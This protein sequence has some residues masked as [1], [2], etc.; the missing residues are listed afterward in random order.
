[1]AEG[2]FDIG[3]NVYHV[4]DNLVY[5][6]EA[7]LLEER[8]PSEKVQRVRRRLGMFGVDTNLVVS[9]ETDEVLHVEGDWKVVVDQDGTDS[10]L[11]SLQK[12]VSMP[13]S[14]PAH[15]VRFVC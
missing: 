1:M 8:A 6:K 3:R 13:T 9:K 4:F 2:A 11:W 15:P 5:A 14:K 10:K 7:G 12:L